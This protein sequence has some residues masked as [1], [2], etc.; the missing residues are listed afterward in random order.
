MA[1]AAAC[2]GQGV[3][4]TRRSLAGHSLRT[5]LLVAPF[6]VTAAPDSHYYLCRDASMPLNGIR[7]SFSLWLK[8]LC[9]RIADVP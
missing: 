2:A 5:G 8:D 6:G 3:M 4:L 9:R 1:M 7:L